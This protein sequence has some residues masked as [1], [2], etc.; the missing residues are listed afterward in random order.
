MFFNFDLTIVNLHYIIVGGNFT[1]GRNFQDERKY[2][3]KRD[4]IKE[5]GPEKLGSIVKYHQ[6]ECPNNDV[7]TSKS[8]SR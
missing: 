5:T 2:L 4:L 1:S 3:K 6:Y 8:G 7:G